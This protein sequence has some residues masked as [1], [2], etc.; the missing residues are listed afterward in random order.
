MSAPAYHVPLKHVQPPTDRLQTNPPA[1]S[2]HSDP[3]V[4][5]SADV[6]S[7]PST[8]ATGFQGSIQ[9]PDLDCNI[10][11]HSPMPT[12]VSPGSIQVP[13]LASNSKELPTLL[14]RSTHLRNPPK[15]MNLK[16]GNS[17]LKCDMT[18]TVS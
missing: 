11:S 14:R 9:V 2:S 6:Q 5:T 8:P 12:I 10:P 16:Q 18:Q 7:H 1:G 3:E 4:I 17:S 15:S 13:N